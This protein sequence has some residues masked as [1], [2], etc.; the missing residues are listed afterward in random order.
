MKKFIVHLLWIN[1][2]FIFSSCSTPYENHVCKPS[3]EKGIL[4]YAETGMLGNLYPLSI[5]NAISQRINFLIH[6]GLVLIDPLT[7]NIKPGIADTWKID[8]SETVYRFFL[9]THVYFHDNECFEK[10][11]GRKLTADDVIFS[12]TKLCTKDENNKFAETFVEQIEGASEFY[13]NKAKNISGLI[14]ENDSTIVI[15]LNKPN[16][17]FLQFLASPAA[18]VYPKEA[19]DKYSTK[20]TVGLGPF[21]IKQFPEN[22]KP[23]FLCKNQRYF[24]MDNKG[25]CLPY[26][27]T[28][29]I[30]FNKTIR[31]QLEMLVNGKIDAVFNIDNESLTSFLEKNIELFEREKAIFKVS[32]VGNFTSVQTQHILRKNIE[33]L[34]INE[35]HQLDLRETKYLNKINDVQATK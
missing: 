4:S 25:Y 19:Y 27:D 8:T 3:E 15:K 18:V 34:K 13:N 11:K 33:N 21:Y 1:V 2:I 35:F 6:E 9:N 20:L 16:P 23:M 14:K 5:D 17:M 29:I 31:E 22:D 32:N 30:Y 28:I 7:L 10:A 12:L 24:K 26:I